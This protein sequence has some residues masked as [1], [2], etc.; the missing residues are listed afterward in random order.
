MDLKFGVISPQDWGLPVTADPS[1]DVIAA[2]GA[3]EADLAARAR[4]ATETWLPQMFD[5]QTGA[6]YGYLSVRDGYR[7]PP[8][9]S[10]LIAPWQLMAAYDRTGNADL[11]DMA[12]QSAEWFYTHHV[13]D[14]PMAVVAG[15]VRDGVATDHLWTKFAGEEIVTCLGLHARTG[16]PRWLDR[17]VRG[18]RYLIQARRH[19]FAP[20]YELSSGRW[21]ALGWD[22]WGR[23]AEAALLLWQALDDPRWMDEAL[24]WGEHGLAIQAANG[25]FYLI[26]G[27]YY[28]T[29]LAAD[30][31]RALTFLYEATGRE[32]FLMAA[33]RFADWHLSQQTDAGAWPLT[34]DADGN[35]VMPTVGPGDV[36]NIAVALL[37]LHAVTHDA[38][39]LDAAQRAMRYS[40]SQQVTPDGEHPYHD[41]PRAQWGFWS[42]DPYY[43]Y[44]LSPDQATH[45]ARG[46]WFLLDYLRA[47]AARS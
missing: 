3:S 34:I 32:P 20:R 25:T 45:H 6:F 38:A 13:T 46:M 19:G 5:A 24:A 7:E 44:T 41:D 8:Q 1:A 30:E 26:D 23:A 4:H 9:T 29:D 43:D 35:V 40:L 14:H 16:E 21:L 10:N 37:R 33:R 2:L 11:L 42:W 12:R 39:Y 22:S 27:E 31:L 17:A 15:G 36:P 28:N 18:G 47:E